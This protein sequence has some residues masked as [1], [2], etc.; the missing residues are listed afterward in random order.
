MRDG[1]ALQMG[2]SHELGQGFAKAF[3]ITFLDEGGQQSFAWQTSWGASSRLMGAIIMAHGDD[4][5]LRVP[6]RLAP[7]QVVVLA[8][9]TEEGAGEAAA[10][11]TE[12]LRAA[13]MRVELDV[14]TD[15]SFG[16]RVVNCELK[17]IPVR[18]EVG[19]RDLAAG[20]VVLSRR[21]DTSKTSL[22]LEGVVAQVA[23]VL[24]STQ[25][26]LY[27]EALRRREENTAR[28][29]TLEE[30]EEA[31]QT[32]FAAVP[33]A[34]LVAGDGEGRLNAGGLTV[35]LLRRPDG[36]LPGGDDPVSE[37]EAVV[38]RAY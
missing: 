6:P 33:G 11:L 21:D 32:G 2:T 35:R 37:L 4:A 31:A 9:R 8:V 25:A 18:V 38:A 28:A 14:R 16:R 20:T 23:E 7:V 12:Q 5:G 22:P 30:A 36:S 10:A 24:E 17:G 13:G 3:G 27:A 19:P 15:L 26:T 29:S 34:V 1:K